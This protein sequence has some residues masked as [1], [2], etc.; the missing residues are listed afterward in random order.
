M[1]ISVALNLNLKGAISI[2]GDLPYDLEYTNKSSTPIYWL[3]AAQDGHITQERKDSWRT[4][5]VLH[6]T[7]HYQ[8]IDHCTHDEI[9]AAFNEIKNILSRL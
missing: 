7:F 2:C 3:E 5:N 4:L 1:A 9:D 6:A 8:K